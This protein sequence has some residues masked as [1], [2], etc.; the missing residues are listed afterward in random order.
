MNERWRLDELVQL[1]G[2]AL[3][4]APYQGQASGRVRDVPDARTIRYYT[5]LGVLDR[6][7]EMR[8]RTAYYG[9]RHLL[10][11]VAVKRL[12][13]RGMS[14]VD[15]QK[16]VAG[17]DNS[18]LK[19]W[20]ALPA[21]FWES[22]LAGHDSALA[23]PA[24]DEL[25]MSEPLVP[26]AEVRARFWAAEPAL[27]ASDE[28]ERCRVGKVAARPGVVLTLAPGVSLFIEGRRVPQLDA[29]GL[30]AMQPA[31]S[32]L[33]VALTRAGILEREAGDNRSPS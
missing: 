23:V 29:D 31:L 4:A 9:R 10:Q 13:A 12:Q 25:L 26:P 6:P 16:N 30:D 5:T 33:L 19:R 27:A 20:A 24:P 1:A 21:E 3:E 2:R 8:G 17:A 7:L 22:V 18:T 28:A 32:E 11:I 14:L 15:I